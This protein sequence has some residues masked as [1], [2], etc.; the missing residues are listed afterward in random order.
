MKTYVDDISDDIQLYLRKS[1]VHTGSFISTSTSSFTAVTASAPSGYT[2]TNEDDFMF[3]I[4]GQLMEHDA[5]TVQQSSSY[6]YLKVDND[7]IGYDVASTD[8][9]VAW[10][11][12]NS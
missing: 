10:G 3:F 4:N 5:L 7:S 8:E 1:F 2:T 11:K 12:F 9:I 6:F